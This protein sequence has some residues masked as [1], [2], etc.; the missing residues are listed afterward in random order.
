MSKLTE[1]IKHTGAEM[2]ELF[3]CAMSANCWLV[4]LITSIVFSQTSL[5]QY[6]SSSL[7][8][9]SLLPI[10]SYRRAATFC[11]VR[12]GKFFFPPLLSQL[13]LFPNSYRKLTLHYFE[14]PHNH[15]SAGR[16]TGFKTKV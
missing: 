16:Q 5:Q 11:T 8:L 7:T 15:F 13:T 14:Q 2:S 3:M 1:I 9:S 12:T 6:V 4:L 10:S